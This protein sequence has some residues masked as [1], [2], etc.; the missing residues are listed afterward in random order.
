MRRVLDDIRGAAMKIT[1]LVC[2]IMSWVGCATA[3]GPAIAEPA[4]PPPASAPDEA[5]AL[6][7][8]LETAHAGVRDFQAKVIYESYD[9]VLERREIRTGKLVFEKTGGRRRLGILFDRVI[10][11]GRAQNRRKDWIFDGAWLIERDHAARL[12]LKRQIVPPGEDFDPLKLGEGPFPL[13]VGQAADEVMARFEV[14]TLEAPG[15]AALAGRM[16]DA[17]TVG[18]LLRPRAGTDL[19]E[20][21]ERIEV[22]YDK[23]TLLPVGILVADRDQDVKT[24]ALRDLEVNKGVDA[25]LLEVENPDPR[26][27]QIDI[28]PWQ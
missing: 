25:A 23:K 27:W 16:K 26:E 10:V 3:P 6:L 7:K 20:D 11:G 22:F 5:A 9:A 13:P 24:A 21:V 18:L 19:A 14:E 8:R 17:D 1:M 2:A 15:D 12:F 28:R 4:T